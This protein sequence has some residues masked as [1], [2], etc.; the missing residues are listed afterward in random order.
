MI[1]FVGGKPSGHLQDTATVTE[2]IALRW[3]LPFFAAGAAHGSR[4]DDL[5]AAILRR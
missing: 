5:V 4:L 1:Q 3:Q 2:W